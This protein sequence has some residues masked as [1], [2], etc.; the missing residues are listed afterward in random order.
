MVNREKLLAMM[1]G[2]ACQ[3]EAEMIRC[4]E[5]LKAL[6]KAPKH[7]SNLRILC[8]RIPTSTPG[9]LV[10]SILKTYLAYATGPCR[11]DHAKGIDAVV[12]W[13]SKVAPG[14]KCIEADDLYQEAY[15]VF[16]EHVADWNRRQMKVV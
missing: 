2:Y 5:A 3:P 8:A 7:L 13:L 15:L 11:P 16:A 10:F 1:I 4:G 12:E 6:S 14:L 9:I